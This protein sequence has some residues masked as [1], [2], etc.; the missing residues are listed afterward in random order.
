MQQS[1]VQAEALAQPGSYITHRDLHFHVDGMCFEV[2]AETTYFVPAGHQLA[3][4]SRTCKR[5]A[6]ETRAYISYLYGYQTVVPS[7][8]RSD[9]KPQYDWTLRELSLKFF[10][11]EREKISDKAKNC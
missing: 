9:C 2:P 10:Q 4:S 11:W 6:S 8:G 1:T 3:G 7:K 5:V